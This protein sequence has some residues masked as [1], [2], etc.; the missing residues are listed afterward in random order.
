MRMITLSLDKCSATK[1]VDEKFMISSLRD[2]PNHR[3]SPSFFQGGTRSPKKS[4]TTVTK[5]STFD[6]SL[7]AVSRGWFGEG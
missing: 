7:S 1:L 4:V 5:L 2:F 3:H 6:M